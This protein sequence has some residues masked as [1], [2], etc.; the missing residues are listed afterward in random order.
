MKTKRKKN[1]L[2]FSIFLVFL[3]ISYTP[4]TADPQD[5]EKP[6]ILITEQNNDSSIHLQFK[7]PQLDYSIK[8]I[9]NQRFTLIQIDDSGFHNVIG[10]AKLPMIRKMIEIPYETNPLIKI[11]TIK[12]KSIRLSE[13]Q[14]PHKI[15][16]KQSPKEKLE[17]SQQNY[18][19]DE[20][21]YTT[22]SF[23]P[24]EIVTLK[25][26]GTIR[27][28]RFALM[29]LAPIQYN[30]TKGVI[31]IIQHCDITLTLPK[32]NIPST[33]KQIQ[34]YTSPS[35]EQL[36]ETL[37]LNYGYYENFAKNTRDQEGYLIIVDD[38]FYDE[39]IPLSNWKES[40]GF[41]TTTTN[42]S[43]IPGG[44]TANNIK[45][46]IKNA[47]TNW[48]IPPSYV[49][50]V[51]D[52]PQIPAFTG[53]VCGT[54]TDS[55]YARMDDDIFPD[56]YISRFP[57]S[58]ELHVQ[59][60]VNKTKYYEQGDFP[61]NH[62]IKKG[63][64]IA[65]ND[66]GGL[67]EDTHN[68]VINT[69]LQP[70]GYT[71][72]KIYESTGGDTQDISDA[73]NE[74]RSLCIYSGHGSPSG[75][76]CVPFYQSD[77]NALT[78][79]GM[80]PFVCSH[81][82]STNTYEDSECFGETW[83]RAEQKGG[84]AFWGSS[85]ST[86]WDEDDVIERRVFDAWWYDGMDRIGQ[87]TDKGMY[88]AYMQNPGLEIERFM[89][90][91]NVMGD[92]SVK[93]W[94]DDPF[95][96]EHDIK[97]EDLTIDDIV[98]HGEIQNVSATIR[99]IGNN[100][101]HNIIV[102]F[103]EDGLSVDTTTISH[104]ESMHETIVTF[105]WNPPIGT[106]LLEIETRP[107]TDEY[108]LTNN[109]V[110]KTVDVIASPFIDIHPTSF[111]FMT[112]TDSTDSN[113]LTISNL[114]SAEA[115]LNYT[116]SFSGDNNG[117]WLSA[118]PNNGTIDIGNSENITITVDTS[119]LN[120]GEYQGNIKIESNDIND[121]EI[122]IPVY[123]TVVYGHD[124]TVLSVNNPNGNISH[125]NHIVNATIQ[126]IGFFNQTNVE[127]NCTIFEGYLDYLEDFED[128]S[129]GYVSGGTPDWEWGDPSIGPSSAHSGVNCWATDL[130]DEYSDDA[131]ATLDSL[132]ISLPQGV[133]SELS[134]WHW[135]DMEDGYSHYDGGNVKISTDG[136]VSWEILGEYLEPYPI[137]YASDTNEGIP[138][139]PCFSGSSSSW[140]YVT[141]NLTEYAGNTIMIRWH[142]G[143]DGSVTKPGWYIDD[144][145]VSGNY[146]RENNTI[147]Y[148]DTEILSIDA[149]E[150]EYVTFYPAW[151]VTQNGFYSIKIETLLEND[152]QNDNDEIVSLVEVFQDVSAPVVSGVHASPD[153]QVSGEC[154]NVSCVVTD[155]TVVDS[156]FVAVSGP[157]GFSPVNVSMVSGGGDVFYY[158]DVYVV[159]GNYSF[160][161]WAEDTSGNSVTTGSFSFCIVNDSYESVSLSLSVGWNLMTVP[162][163]KEWYASDL[164][165]EVVGCTSVS[166]WNASLQTYD[167]FIVGG[168][169]S[170]DF[171]IVEGHG[172]FVDV[173]ESSMVTM[174]G[175]PIEDVNVS[176]DVGW[177]LIGWYHDFNTTASS[178]AGNISGCTSVSKWNATM[179]TY[180]TFIVGGPPSFDFT[181]SC[182][183]GL[184]VE[185]NETSYWNGD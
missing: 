78:N 54:E 10:Q 117:D 12:S 116:I 60:M 16:P 84:L 2:I 6:Y 70:N 72:D 17:F 99:N 32:S 34:K 15:I 67:A 177:N 91:Y 139:E 170:F 18:D 106:Y 165:S 55:Y 175:L 163:E 1:S 140:E 30:P 121:P 74:G 39:I 96:P 104:L 137:Q 108:D 120:E 20:K 184:F 43:D 66:Q 61:S 29:E 153:V 90:S 101:E 183:M 11:N 142:F 41:E 111:S 109:N 102:D 178:L 53:S 22:N 162:V 65:S 50:L 80:Y 147:V 46:Y 44:P 87:M 112:P 138:H 82:C 148:Q 172:Y 28:R 182:G 71:C 81:A 58:T 49:L 56:I 181:V 76:A 143:S 57:A 45:L 160:F 19:I 113:I 52:T 154:V 75:W 150:T 130:D 4:I 25:E 122:F 146:E 123:L 136:G 164:A 33:I 24:K 62:W 107:V 105:Q 69:H 59:T 8:T 100:T 3:L 168:P 42:T 119:G 64:F 126:N 68:Y 89:E 173:D 157:V 14:L 134:F 79:D 127:I 124:L 115:Q 40:L 27:G 159:E 5:D 97:V 169:P 128:D 95:I 93:I 171:P 180:D 7:N 156:V 51:G 176:L 132:P 85:C 135:Y 48:S 144:V 167:T 118:N 158:E 98:P 110:N 9:N 92:S 179:Q 38:L 36:F 185:V 77:V 161:V 149:Y 23:L 83:L 103:I 94:S 21:Y 35:F 166:K 37:F 141:F 152:E 31:H 133:T 125:G 13:L 63:A 151:N 145:H 47:Y 114:P 174:V 88:D 73:L 155:E 129:G 86:Y 131:S 26:I